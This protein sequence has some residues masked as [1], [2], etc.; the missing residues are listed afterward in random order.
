MCFFGSD[1]NGMPPARYIDP[2]EG[3]KFVTSGGSGL[4]YAVPNNT[5]EIMK[6]CSHDPESIRNIDI[7]KNIY[8]NMMSAGQHPHVVK[9]IRILDNGVV[10]E[11]AKHGD[12]REYFKRGG[13]ATMAERIKWCKDLASAVDF[14]HGLHIRHADICGKNILLDA[15]RNIK[16]CDFAGSSFCGTSPSV[17]A[18]L[19]YAH[20]NQNHTRR[21]TVIA[22][23]HS[24]GS[25]MY[26]ILTSSRPFDF[27]QRP[28]IVSQWLRHGVYPSVDQ[29]PLGDIIMACW[30]G[31]Y[32]C[33][34]Q[35]E[36][37]IQDVIESGSF[38]P[39]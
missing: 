13:T 5:T 1:D 15:N 9:C 30:K 38:T 37:A 22:E 12:L 4:L 17:S 36:H 24:L 21:A 28:A 2:P 31:K 23:M 25:T 35:V 32:P 6:I 7:E 18:E 39:I 11:R 20:P 29:L 3:A 26:E 10:L 14:I 27:E 8:E 34:L 33:V 19:G 16:L